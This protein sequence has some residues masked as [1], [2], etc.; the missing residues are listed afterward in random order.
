MAERIIQFPC[1]LI[2]K[3]NCSNSRYNSDDYEGDLNRSISIIMKLCY[4][5]NISILQFV[6]LTRKDDP[7]IFKFSCFTV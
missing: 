4:N 1:Q 5:G 3:Y 7:V 6:K 2:T